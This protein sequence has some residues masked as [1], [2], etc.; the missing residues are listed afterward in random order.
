MG[1]AQAGARAFQLFEA[2]NM[3]TTVRMTRDHRPIVHDAR[4]P[5]GGRDDGPLEA[6]SA[7]T[8][9][10]RKSMGSENY[11][12]ACLLL[13]YFTS[14]LQGPNGG[15][16]ELDASAMDSRLRDG[17]SELAKMFPDAANPR[18]NYR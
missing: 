16:G 9:H 11:A 4:F 1:V 18:C 3:T 14:A 7:L 5:I 10:L 13:D 15:E 17:P 2:L 12:K 8:D 6:R